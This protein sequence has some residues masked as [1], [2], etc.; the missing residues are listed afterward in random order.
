MHGIATLGWDD[1]LGR[2][3]GLLMDGQVGT[4]KWSPNGWPSWDD[5]V[6][7]ITGGY[8]LK[9]Q[10]ALS[11]KDILFCGFLSGQAGDMGDDE[12]LLRELE[13][14]MGP[15][16]EVDQLGLNMAKLSVKE[17]GEE[18]NLL[19]HLEHLPPVPTGAMPIPTGVTCTGA[20]TGVT[21]TPTTGVM[22][23]S[24]TT[25]KTKKKDRNIP[26]LAS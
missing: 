24:S 15:E 14:L 4:T 11:L 19:E 6:V 21:G 3:S 8:S 18:G 25:N 16:L 20:P 10:V 13:G 23:T 17:E 9:L 12:E 5:Q 2:P 22:S 26:Q 1:K 7:L